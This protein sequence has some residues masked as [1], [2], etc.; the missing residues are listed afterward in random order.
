M[1]AGRNAKG[2]FVKGHKVGRKSGKKKSS[3]SG[4]KRRRSTRYQVTSGTMSL[5]RANPGAPAAARAVLAGF[6]GAAG[7]FGITYLTDKIVNPW[8]KVLAITGAAVGTGIVMAKANLGEGAAVLGALSG[9]QA[10]AIAG[11]ELK[12]MMT[13]KDVKGIVRMTPDGQ[14]AGVVG[15]AQLAQASYPQ[16]AYPQTYDRDRDIRGLVSQQYPGI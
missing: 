2:Q 13:K 14:I 6:A 1:A 11:F 12:A 4:T 10:V 7:S 3:S 16:S 8:G 9:S 5:R 15:P